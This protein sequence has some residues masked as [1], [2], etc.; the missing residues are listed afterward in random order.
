MIKIVHTDGSCCWVNPDHI[1]KMKRLPAQTLIHLTDGK[2]INSSDDCETIATN[3]RNWYYQKTINP[4]TVPS[5]TPYPQY[6]PIPGVPT[7]TWSTTSSGVPQGGNYT[8][9]NHPPIPAPNYGNIAPLGQL[10]GPQ[11]TAA[12][13]YTQ[14]VAVQ[15]YDPSTDKR[16]RNCTP[17]DPSG[18]GSFRG[19]DGAG[20]ASLPVARK[21]CK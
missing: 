16:G 18:D 17:L 15:N 7:Y 13:Q 11:T 8:I 10:A 14:A 19:P 9:P 21:S 2:L 1:I 4:Y 20:I 5:Y 3:I 6:A 12:Q